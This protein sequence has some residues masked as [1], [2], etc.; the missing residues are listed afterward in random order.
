[1]EPRAAKRVVITGGS[2]GIGKA[3]AYQYAA[4]GSEVIILSRNVEA[5]TEICMDIASKGGSCRF[6]RCDVSV[7]EDVRDGLAF[8]A[9]SMGGI[10]LAI[11]NAG[12]GDPEWV[13]E[14]ESEAFEYTFG[15]NVFGL[16]YAVEFLV[17][18]MTEQGFGHIAAVTSL[19]DVRG[20]PGSSSYCASKA[21]ASVFMESSRVEL[22]ALGITVSTIRPGFVKTPMTD[23]N[24]FAMPFLWQ[25]DR[26]AKYMKRKLDLGRD[27][28]Q[29]PTAMVFITYWVRAL[30]NWI[31]TSMA[32]G[33][34]NK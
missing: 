29:F 8:A 23:K 33:A 18:L 10:D 13:S 2:S 22:R 27:I 17:P 5:Q 31:Y 4:A 15:V 28:I 1:M 16:A 14:L 34:R 25:A 12:V 32:A 24:E 21:A 6:M 20:Y 11:L 7:K 19:A 26:A 9:E 30:P 3:L